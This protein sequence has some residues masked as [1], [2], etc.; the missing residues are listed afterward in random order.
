MP[1]VR[2]PEFQRELDHI[3]EI[4]TSKNRVAWWVRLIVSALVLFG[5]A[6]TLEQLNMSDSY[7]MAG[8]VIVCSLAII[9]AI[10]SAASYLGSVLTILIGTTEWIGRKQLGEYQQPE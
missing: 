7:K 3:A 2:D 8:V 6:Y 10:I 1:L 5:G 9:N 4:M